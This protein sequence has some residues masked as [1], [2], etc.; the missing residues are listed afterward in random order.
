MTTASD[1]TR[2][3]TDA[4]GGGDATAVPTLAGVV[5]GLSST[6]THAPAIARA[7]IGLGGELTRVAVGRSD[8]SPRKGDWRFKD[9]TWRTNPLYRRL[10][11]AYLAT[12]E[13]I[14]SV[15]DDMESRR[16]GGDGASFEAERA[17]FAT[18]LLTTA[19]AP[20][21]SLLGNPEALKKTFETGGANIVRGARNFLEDLR[22]NGGMPSSTKRDALR[23]GEDMAV[24]AGEVIDR[25]HVAEVIQYAPS[26]RKVRERPVLLIPP[27]IG[28]YYF[29]DLQPGRSLIEYS[30]SRGMSTFILSWRNPSPNEAD[31]TMDTYVERILSA[32]DVVR[33]ATGADDIH[34]MG[35]CAGGILMTTALSYLAHHG[36]SSV[37]SASYGVTML[38]YK[39]LAPIQAFRSA[40]LI[41][42]ARWNSAKAGVI[43]AR[44]M[45]SAFT[46]MRP[47]DL[48]WNYWV[49]NYLLGQD[50]PVFDILAWNADG[51]NLPAA[52]H[53]QFLDIFEQDT[54]AQ[55]GAVE[56]LGTPVDLDTIKVPIFVVGAVNDHLTPWRACFATTELLAGD[57]TFVLSN[58]GHIASLVNPPGNPKSSYFVGPLA[59]QLDPDEWL[60]SAEPRTGSWWE[61][62][63]DWVIERS[64]DQVPAPRQLGSATFPPLGPAPGEY[65]RS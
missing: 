61:Y 38:R 21:N 40:R 57:S 24:T 20:T 47:N 25:D 18:T 50:P 43:S 12:C 58:A 22:H 8:V 37:H 59:G 11:Q 42:F 45:G 34:L 48:V 31:W 41:S 53:R 64:G 2:A 30:V 23:V 14:D 35:F 17:R 9:P 33:E 54:L 27:P 32:I 15:V 28:R 6:L 10:G 7:T 13:A 16:G 49:N 55:P 62:W 60:K 1:L 5:S 63:T 19:L 46:W 39:E 56:V 44:A 26:T 65:V 51:T 36:E 4:I 52:L 29:L 3:A